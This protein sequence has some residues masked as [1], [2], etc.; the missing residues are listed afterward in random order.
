MRRTINSEADA[1]DRKER[2]C[3]IGI[4][5]WVSI[6]GGFLNRNELV[7]VLT[8]TKEI[9]TLKSWLVR[10]QAQCSR[11]EKQHSPDN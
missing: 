7:A 6:P 5:R 10:V 1:V 8:I 9:P 11:R 4:H 2:L 3:D